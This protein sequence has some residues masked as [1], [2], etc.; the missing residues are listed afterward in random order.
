MDLQGQRNRFAFRVLFRSATLFVS[1]YTDIH[2]EPIWEG[3]STSLLLFF[4]CNIPAWGSFSS[5]TQDRCLHDFEYVDLPN[6]LL[7]VYL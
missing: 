2:V 5:A 4:R 1:L 3:A 6:N 7:V